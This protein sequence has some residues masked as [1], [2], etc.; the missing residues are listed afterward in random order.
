MC[1]WLDEL[2]PDFL[3]SI[4]GEIPFQ[5]MRDIKQ[6]VETL[7]LIAIGSFLG[8]SVIFRQRRLV[9]W[10]LIPL[11]VWLAYIAIPRY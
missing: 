6:T 1:L 11:L 2:D 3:S 4:Y 5:Q 8:I 7:A 10:G 9:Q